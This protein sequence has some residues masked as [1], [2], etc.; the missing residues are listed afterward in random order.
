V[1]KGIGDTWSFA[2]PRQ[3]FGRTRKVRVSIVV[4]TTILTVVTAGV[5]LADNT[6]SDGDGVVPY[7]DNDLSFGNICAGQAATRTV[8]IWIQRSGSGP[9]V[10]ANGATV[11]VSV[12]STTGTGLSAVMGSPSTITLPSNWADLANNTPSGTVSATVTLNSTAIGSFSGS[13]VFRGSGQNGS[14]TTINREDTMAVTANV[15]NCTPAD[16]TPPEITYQ[17]NPA[18]PDGNDDW[19]KS[20]VTLTWTVTENES[21]SSL[22]KNGCVDQ[23][24]TTDQDETTYSCSASSDGGSAGPVEVTI[25]RDATTPT[26][27]PSVT[28]NPVVL[29]GSATASAGA[30]DNLSGVASSSC[31]AVDTSSVG[32]KSVTCSAEDYA[33]NTNSASASYSV[34]YTWSGFFQPVDNSGWNSA[35]AGQSIPV[36]FSLGGDQGL[37]VLKNG[38]PSRASATCPSAS[39]PVDPV[40]E[41]VTGTANNGLVYDATANQYNYVWKTDKAW[42]GKCFTFELGLKDG[43]SHTFKVQFTK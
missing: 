31:D 5:A 23:S 11:T 20:N 25:K 1:N 36:K 19:Y 29:N 8:P 35:K 41:Y 34:I 14:G 24:I 22:T 18:S 10:F 40:E 13:V 3:P 42:A 28:P 21:P 17:L 39:T 27:S 12:L 9:N 43:S 7:A 2:T 32:S 15:Q 33:G 38:Y 26:L 30:N 4:I 6:Q 16:S 37:Q